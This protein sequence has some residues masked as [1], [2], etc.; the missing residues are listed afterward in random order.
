MKKRE[1]MKKRVLLLM[2]S[3]MLLLSACGKTGGGPDEKTEG[4]FR[5]ITDGLGRQVRVPEKIDRIVTLGN[6]TRMVVYLGLEEKLVSTANGDVSDNL[7]QAYGAY[8]QERW[9][10]LPVVAS[11]GYGE[12]NTEAILAADPDVILCTYEQEIVENLEAQ[13]GRQVVAAPQ[14]KLFQEDFE[15]AMRIFGQACGVSERAEEV[16]SFIHDQLDQL[17]ERADSVPAEQRPSVLAAAA[18]SRTAHGISTVYANSAVLAAIG[19]NDVT[20]D[21]SQGPKGLEVDREQILAWDPEWIV[22]DAGNV[23]LVQAEYAE[24]PDYFSHLKAVEEGRLYQWPNSS[25]N[26]SNIEI[27]LASAWY[28]GKLLYPEAFSDIDPET[29]AQEIYDFFLGHGE[30]GK[31]LE[32]NGLGFGPVTLG[33]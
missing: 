20:R 7:L 32:E 15:T 25:A 9:K 2:L 16:L 21:L 29:R 23:Y 3:A 5:T 11:G 17:A 24:D 6:A 22:L 27:P 19:A 1:N 14:G 30:Y 31:L 10:E 12:V 18:T 4:E 13:L 28:M 26:Y 33:E 8:H